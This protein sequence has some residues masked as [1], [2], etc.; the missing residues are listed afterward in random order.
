MTM[1]ITTTAKSSNQAN[2]LVLA[3]VLAL[4]PA[5]LRLDNERTT[6]DGVDHSVAGAE[7][8]VAPS[9]RV[10]N[11][12]AT[13]GKLIVLR[14]D[15][16]E[17]NLLDLAAVGVLGDGADIKDTETSLVVGLVGETFVDELV[18]VDGAGGRL[19]V[20]GVLGL[21]QAGD[22]PDVGDRETILGWRVGCSTRGVDLTLVKLVVH[23]EVSL[24]HRVEDPALVS[25]RCTDVRSTRDDL[26]GFGTVLVGDIVDGEGVL[27]VTVA[28]IAAKVLLVGAAVNN[29]LSIVGVAVLRRAASLVRLVGV[30]QVDE[31][32]ATGTGVV[33]A[34][35]ATTA[36]S[37]GVA[38]LLVGNDVVRT[39]R[40]TVG[41][42]HPADILLDIEG[43]GVL[44]AQLEQ[45]LHVEELDAVASTL[46]SDDQSVSDLL[47][48]APNDTVVA[49][50]QT[51]EV[52]ELTLLSDLCEGS[53]VSLANGYKFP[54]GTLVSPTPAAG[55]FANGIAE[56][57]VGLEVVKVLEAWLVFCSPSKA[58]D[59]VLRCPCSCRSGSCHP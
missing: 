40:D 5:E 54:A 25:V 55:A 58:F 47:D 57:C 44:G 1:C 13:T 56:L 33:T 49:G 34:N 16:E 35:A 45:L 6:V 7:S 42:V 52:F 11:S 27:V 18:V 4:A 59:L 46:R 22:V 15:V 10:P 23:N 36:N 53:T 37:D 24:P 14:V 2:S 38:E 12:R 28:D 19:V 51:A 17:S 20:A 3:P 50:R 26:A 39:A 41:D 32:R 48:L 29:A 43:L 8:E 21:L 31:D 9:A 30:V